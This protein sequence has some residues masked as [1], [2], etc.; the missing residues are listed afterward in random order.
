MKSHFFLPSMAVF[1]VKNKQK[2]ILS[3]L[4]AKCLLLV[5]RVGRRQDFFIFLFQYFCYPTTSQKLLQ[6]RR[7]V[8]TAGEVV[9]VSEIKGSGDHQICPFSC[10]KDQPRGKETISGYNAQPALGFHF[11]WGIPACSSPVK[12][13]GNWGGTLDKMRCTIAPS[14][15]TFQPSSITSCVLI[16]SSALSLWQPSFLLTQL[17]VNFKHCPWTAS[18]IK[19]HL[20]LITLLIHIKFLSGPR[21]KPSPPHSSPILMSLEFVLPGFPQVYPWSQCVLL[22]THTLLRKAQR[23]YFQQ[24]LSSNRPC[25]LHHGLLSRMVPS[26]KLFIYSLPNLIPWI[27]FLWQDSVSGSWHWGRFLCHKLS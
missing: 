18:F 14:Y 13:L 4:I 8:L 9:L 6:K 26:Y 5:L 10:S 3:N 23:P 25:S 20:D 11:L 15:P 21:Y 22:F 24:T 7:P 12:I 27:V 19:P 1:T 17:L 2:N 16:I